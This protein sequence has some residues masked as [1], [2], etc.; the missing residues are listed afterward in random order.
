[1][2]RK[3]FKQAQQDKVDM[4]ING[5]DLAD[6]MAQLEIDMME[7]AQKIDKCKNKKQKQKL[8]LRLEKLTQIALTVGSGNV[9]L[10]NH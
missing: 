3:A 1:M 6:T 9:S 5:R 8:N 10:L 2:D 4:M 7:L